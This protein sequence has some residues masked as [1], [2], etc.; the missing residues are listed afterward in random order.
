MSGSSDQVSKILT[1]NSEFSS[2]FNPS[3]HGGASHPSL[4]VP[5]GGSMTL[6]QSDY[7]KNL[8]PAGGGA[9]HDPY[10]EYNGMTLSDMRYWMRNKE[11]TVYENCSLVSFELLHCRT[12]SMQFIRCEI[13]RMRMVSIAM[14]A[15][16][17]V[18]D[19]CH[20][21]CRRAAHDA[22]LMRERWTS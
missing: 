13:M 15:T 16:G 2:A 4:V 20:L 21:A 14:H 18:F 5:Q 11:G 3:Y 7:N 10:S 1:E 19:R 22:Y 8:D 9:G 17:M 12:S 6:Y